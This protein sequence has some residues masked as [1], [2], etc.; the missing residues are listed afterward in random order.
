MSQN[1]LTDELMC[2]SPCDQV[3]GIMVTHH[4]P[5]E[6]CRPP[7]P[8]VDGYVILDFPNAYVNHSPMRKDFAGFPLPSG[9]GICDVDQRG[10][11]RN[12]SNPSF[13]VTVTQNQN[14]ETLHRFNE[15]VHLVLEGSL[16]LELSTES[17]YTR[18]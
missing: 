2:M 8:V 13:V 7:L 5:E 15:S 9:K 4:A 6:S 10:V 11:T 16:L 14:P 17:R 18:V 1:I 12:P 3:Y